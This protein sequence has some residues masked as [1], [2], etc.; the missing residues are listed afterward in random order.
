[1]DTEPLIYSYGTMQDPLETK[2]PAKEYYTPPPLREE[3]RIMLNDAME[4]TSSFDETKMHKLTS[5]PEQV[6]GCEP[7]PLFYE[8]FAEVSGPL[9]L[10]H[11]QALVP[12]SRRDG[13]HVV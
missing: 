9:A 8:V 7:L 12:D 3:E 13:V 1:M 5:L 10:G 2:A 6:E 11:L 4:G